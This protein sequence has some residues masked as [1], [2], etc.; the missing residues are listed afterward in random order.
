MS[1]LSV[2]RKLRAT[3]PIVSL[4]PMDRQQE[5]SRRLAWYHARGVVSNGKRRTD[6]NRREGKQLEP[7]FFSPLS[8]SAESTERYTVNTN[9]C[10]TLVYSK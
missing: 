7:G 10:R 3:L 9:I 1:N 2:D 8:L 4:V 5:A 6:A